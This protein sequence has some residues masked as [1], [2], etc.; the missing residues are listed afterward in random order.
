MSTE[1][2]AGSDSV[3]RDR[4]Q[5]QSLLGHGGMGMVW[6]AHDRRL[7]RTVALKLLRPDV[8]ESTAAQMEREARAAARVDDPRIVNVL[9]LDHMEDGRPFLV[10]ELHD[11]WTLSDEL[12][13]GALEPDRFQLLTEDLLGGLAAAHECGVLHRDVK[14]ANVLAEVGGYRITD[15]GL[16]SIGTNQQTEPSLMGTLS[17]IAPERLHGTPGT[18]TA[19]VFSAA[20]VLYEAA[21]GHKPFL[22]DTP[23]DAIMA[24][25]ARRIAPLPD[26]VPSALRDTILLALDPDPAHRPPDAQR[27]LAATRVDGHVDSHDR[28]LILPDEDDETRPFAPVAPEATGA[29][30][31]TE[32]PSPRS[33]HTQSFASEPPP[34]P[35]ERADSQEP[36]DETRSPRPF[37]RRRPDLLVAAAVALSLMFVLGTIV[38]G[39]DDGAGSGTSGSVPTVSS[40]APP[41]SVAESGT[42]T[43]GDQQAPSRSQDPAQRLNDALSQIEEL[44]R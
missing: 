16:A 41:T 33:G 39:G 31:T 8:P 27:M 35:P 43:G 6:S 22:A 25:R 38:S 12:Q 26:H 28:T 2:P 4:Y 14:P 30:T 23:A 29:N 3:I 10:L 34:D 9:D 36:S 5:L 21:A 42:P 40:E 37:W 18:Y 19:D 15:F 1:A 17:Y 13:S 24:V 11:G 7:D 44:G 20:V 32:L